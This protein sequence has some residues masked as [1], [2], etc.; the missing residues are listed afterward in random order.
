[1]V[2]R[3][4]LATPQEVADHLRKAVRT[5]EQWR[6]LGI[7]PRYVKPTAKSVLYRWSDVDAWIAENVRG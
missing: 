7:G 2:E 4:G 3:E 1:M 6:Y 5:L